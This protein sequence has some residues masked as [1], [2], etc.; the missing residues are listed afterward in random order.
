MH[1]ANATDP[2]MPAA[3]EPIVLGL[4]GLDDFY[5]KPPHGHFKQTSSNPKLT[6]DG[7]NYLAPDDI[8]TIYDI[9]RLYQAGIDGSG[10]KIAIAGTSDIALADIA[11]FQD[12][13]GLPAHVPKVTL[14]AGSIDPGTTAA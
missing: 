12:A 4:L 11:A 10:L 1:F 7:Q 8:A 2:T 9:S 3:L 6:L 14:A 5:P 13:F